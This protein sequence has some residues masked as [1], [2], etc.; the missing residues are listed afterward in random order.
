MK[1]L[2]TVFLSMLAVPLILAQACTAQTQIKDSAGGIN[3]PLIGG[4]GSNIVTYSNSVVIPNRTCTI[5]FKSGNLTTEGCDFSLPMKNPKMTP[6]AIDHVKFEFDQPY[7][8]L[9]T[10]IT[11]SYNI[12]K[13]R[14]Q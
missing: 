14:Q 8:I 7:A 1:K 3:T 9:G 2:A 6:I 10:G 4:T 12:P 11:P 5:T 13:D